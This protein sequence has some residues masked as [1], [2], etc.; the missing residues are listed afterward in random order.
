MNKLKVEG[1]LEDLATLAKY[2][3]QAEEAG[4]QYTTIGGAGVACHV[5][6]AHG[7]NAMKMWEE[8]DRDTDDIDIVV[9]VPQFY[10]LLGYGKPQKSLSIAGKYVI[11]EGGTH[12]DIYVPEHVNERWTKLIGVYL[13]GNIFSDSE[14]ISPY[15]EGSGEIKV[16][17]IPHLLKLKY[18][19]VSSMRNHPRRKDL[20]DL[21]FLMDLLYSHGKDPSELFSTEPW[22]LHTLEEVYRDVRKGKGYFYL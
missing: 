2:A 10:W 13:N 1:A 19:V 8:F 7:P 14:I 3:N 15:G 4:I 11:R 9:S 12:I 17:S 6:K 5:I 18:H 21:Y 22:V 20:V 16:A